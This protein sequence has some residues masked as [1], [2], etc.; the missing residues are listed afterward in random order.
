MPGG[1]L[2]P[3]VDDMAVTC[4]QFCKT[5]GE[6][7]VD[8]EFN[9]EGGPA[10]QSKKDAFKGKI[11]HVTD[12]TFPVYGFKLQEIFSKEFKYT[13][14]IE[15]PGIAHVINM[16]YGTQISTSLARSVLESWPL[17]AVSALLAYLAAFAVWITDRVG[18]YE[19]F[20]RSFL[21]GMWEGF[22]WAY[23]TMT[24]VGYGDRLPLSFVAR[25]I[26]IV[27]TV[28]GVILTGLLVSA[29]SV[30]LTGETIGLDYKLYG[31]K[32]A[33]IH[34]SAEYHFGLRRNAKFDKDSI[35]QNFEEIYELLSSNQIGG[36]LIDGYVVGTKKHLFEKPFLRIYKMY[37]YSSVYGVVSGGDSRKLATCFR[38]YM[39][40]NIAKIFGHVAENVQAIEV[41]SQPIEVV[42]SSGLFD[43]STDLFRKNLMIVGAM[44]CFGL[45]AGSIWEVFY[46]I[47]SK[48]KI[49]P[50]KNRTFPSSEMREMV[51]GLKNRMNSLVLE[52]KEKHHRQ[53][54]GLLALKKNDHKVRCK[55]IE[56]E[57]EF[58]RQC[59][60]DSLDNNDLSTEIVVRKTICENDMNK[61]RK[62]HVKLPLN[63][64][65]E[66]DC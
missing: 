41:S 5:H 66:I 61:G 36:V 44:L 40:K 15:S 42:R 35:H 32:I 21:S 7:Y 9:G 19:H 53:K 10:M 56:N 52:L 20:P 25:I 4:C 47:R 38:R 62:M 3:F 31:A 64:S 30:C 54:Q 18:N 28:A 27:W 16:N 43:P 6:S 55:Q 12:F 33:A 22:W 17:F 2:S 23:V 8:Y 24:T 11:D 14:I 34:G 60:R 50:Q 51:E 65:H 59:R 39:Q 57:L 1:L 13:G 58:S 49:S 46:R 48:M 26:A 63:V 37:D 29:I 45:L